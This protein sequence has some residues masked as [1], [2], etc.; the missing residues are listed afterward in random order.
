MAGVLTGTP[1]PEIQATLLDGTRWSLGASQGIPALLVTVGDGQRSIDALRNAQDLQTTLGG[2][3]LQ[4]I[5]VVGISDENGVNELLRAAAWRA[6]AIWDRNGAVTERLSGQLAMQSALY[7]ID[8][9]GTVRQI[10]ATA[11]SEEEMETALEELAYD[12][13]VG[14]VTIESDRPDWEVRLIAEGIA[15]VIDFADHLGLPRPRRTTVFSYADLFRGHGLL[16]E[17]GGHWMSSWLLRRYW[18][19][20]QRRSSRIWLPKA[21]RFSA[22]LAMAKSYAYPYGLETPARLD[23]LALAGMT[24]QFTLH[25]LEHAGYGSIQDQLTY[26]VATWQSSGHAWMSETI[27]WALTGESE[28]ETGAD[29]VSIALDGE[30]LGINQWTTRLFGTLALEWLG[31]TPL[32]VIGAFHGRSVATASQSGAEQM[33]PL[34]SVDLDA[35]EKHL[36]QTEVIPSDR[37][38]FGV[39]VQFGDVPA[40]GVGGVYWCAFSREW[41]DYIDGPLPWWPHS[42]NRGE[43]PDCYESAIGGSGTATVTLPAGRY[44]FMYE[45]DGQAAFVGAFGI[46]PFG[47]RPAFFDGVLPGYRLEIE[48]NLIRIAETP[49]WITINVVGFTDFWPG[50]NLC[51]AARH[52]HWCWRWGPLLSSSVEQVYGI[53]EGHYWL[54]PNESGPSKPVAL[55]G[56][57]GSEIEIVKQFRRDLAL[58]V[59]NDASPSTLTIKEQ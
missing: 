41:H 16:R 36:R 8:A 14:D 1:A 44:D 18:N 24:Y 42:R 15:A 52:R 21:D 55:I 33:T 2:N 51:I 30:A 13:D 25:A 6:S 27:R 17:E 29:N 49:A 34:L 43:R 39:E 59:D 32:E 40:E 54:F 38:E 3:R 22:A 45:V 19:D 31:V 28:V 9:G 7:L 57:R 23:P 11:P 26:E 37:P 58:S 56:I 53:P 10:W 50:D 12:L 20:T 5:A 35:F 46:T 47:I 48:G 4:L